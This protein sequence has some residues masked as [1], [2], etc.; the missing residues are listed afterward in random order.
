MISDGCDFKEFVE[1]VKDND[2]WDILQIAELEATDAERRFYSGKIA[3][4]DRQK[5]GKQYAETLK[6][7]L[8]FMRYGIKLRGVSKEDYQL[9]QAVY[10]L[11]RS[12]GN[13][14]N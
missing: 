6:C 7:F 10:R 11:V 14:E 3:S 8:S 9:F 13:F 4:V 5:C 1:A 12:R 2:I